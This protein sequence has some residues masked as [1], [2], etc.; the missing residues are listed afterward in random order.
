[1]RQGEMENKHKALIYYQ[2]KGLPAKKAKDWS[3]L[4][5]WFTPERE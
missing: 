2:A 4:K 1:M 5:M 3:T